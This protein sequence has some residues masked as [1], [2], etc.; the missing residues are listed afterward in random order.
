MELPH[1]WNVNLKPVEFIVENR[2]KDEFDVVDLLDV[3]GIPAAKKSHAGT[4][5]YRVPFLA[6]V[7]DLDALRSH[8]RMRWTD[9]RS[10][11]T[12][13]LRSVSFLRDLDLSLT[14]ACRRQIPAVT[15]SISGESDCVYKK[16]S[17]L[18]SQRMKS[19]SDLLMA[20]PWVSGSELLSP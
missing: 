2:L 19:M 18:A 10:W 4:E 15:I 14:S 8:L 5:I 20:I 7:L 17:T 9:K 3:S 6:E 13:F 12:I 11:G 16:I 1:L